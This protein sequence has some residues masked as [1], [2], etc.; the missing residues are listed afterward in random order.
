MISRNRILLAGCA[1]VALSLAV[2][3]SPA[4][5]DENPVGNLV[6]NTLFGWAD[7]PKSVVDEVEKRGP[8]GLVTGIVFTGP[9]NIVARYASDVVD[10]VAIPATGKN[11][12]QPATLA[13]GKPPIV[14]R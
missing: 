7:G 9:V 10:L 4:R 13:S 2:I 1:A 8:I 6:G 3:S 5:A 14:L 11:T 12:L